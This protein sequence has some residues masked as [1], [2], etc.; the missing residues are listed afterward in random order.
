MSIDV[1]KLPVP[2]LPTLISLKAT[3]PNDLDV[4][5]VASEW[6]NSLSNAIESNNP[7]NAACLF[8]EDCWWRDMLALTW[9]FRTF[10][11]TPAIRTF[12][13]DRIGTTHPRGFKLRQDFLGLQRPYEDLAWITAFFDFETDTGIGFGIFRLVPTASSEW[14]AHVVY[15]NLEDLKGFP[16]K[17]GALRN[18][19]PNHGH[20][21]E[22]RD[23]EKEFE[24]SDP[25]VLIIGGGQSGLDVAARLKSYDIPTLVIEKNE[26]V[27]DNWRNRYE[28]LCLHDVVCEFQIYIPGALNLCF[29]TAQGMITCRI[30]RECMSA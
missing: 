9:D 24:R 10:R 27:G 14:K 15:T 29:L 3:V 17:I 11:G 23:R 20:W 4:Q 2:P 30:F 26:R 28:A 6:L 25:V 21:E 22:N 12:L 1:S 19:E 7:D 18:T 13:C 16:E 8:V 5:K